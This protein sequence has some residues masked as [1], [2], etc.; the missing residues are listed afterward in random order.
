MND[1]LLIAKDEEQAKLITT[2]WERNADKAIA[3]LYSV[4]MMDI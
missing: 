3:A 4:L 2:N 1:I